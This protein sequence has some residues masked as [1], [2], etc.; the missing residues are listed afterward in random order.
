MALGQKNQC[1]NLALKTLWDSLRE[2]IPLQRPPMTLFP[3]VVDCDFIDDLL[4]SYI[5]ASSLCRTRATRH[6]LASILKPRSIALQ[7]MLCTTDGIPWHWQGGRL[8]E[9]PRGALEAA[10]CLT[11]TRT[12]PLRKIRQALVALHKMGPLTKPFSNSHAVNNSIR[13]GQ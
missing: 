5:G 4:F 10:A 8:A 3:Q 12:Q 11:Q 1:R 9:S 2:A 13:R 7:S 6:T